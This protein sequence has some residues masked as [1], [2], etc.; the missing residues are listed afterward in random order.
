VLL[1]AVG[2]VLL[3]ACANWRICCWRGLTSRKR[4]LATRAALGAGR[5]QIV[6]QLLTESLAL[7][8]SGGLLGLILA[9]SGFAFC[10][11]LILAAFRAWEKTGSASR[12][13]TNILLFTL[14]SPF[15]QA[16]SSGWFPAISASRPNLAAT[17]NEG[18][19]RS[20]MGMRSGKLR[21]ALVVSEM[22]MAL[23]LV[24]GAALL[25]RTFLKLESVDPVLK[26]ATWLTMTMSVSGDR[27]QKT[28][29]VAQ[30]TATAENAS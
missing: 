7:S 14:E 3:I 10:S 11:R 18:G 4:E 20:S 13:D 1:G 2:M 15:S 30:V 24:I 5:A 16:F 22:A 8:L 19:S 12:L 9:L 25:I 21:S 27:F 29:P 17:L 26:L 28:A 6:R 23:I